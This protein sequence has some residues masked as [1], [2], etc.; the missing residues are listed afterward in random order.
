MRQ[1]VEV[2]RQASRSC[3]ERRGH[4]SGASRSC[5]ERRARPSSPRG[6]ASTKW[7]TVTNPQ[8]NAVLRTMALERDPKARG[9]LRK[10][11]MSEEHVRA[12]TRSWVSCVESDLSMQ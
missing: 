6:Q 8:M 7:V 12:I 11:W 2:M 5:V 9:R 4:A 3:V 1:S 10:S